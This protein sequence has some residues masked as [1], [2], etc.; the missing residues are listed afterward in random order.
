M[1]GEITI[2]PSCFPKVQYQRF[3]AVEAA[4]ARTE[5]GKQF[6]PYYCPECKAWHIKD[7]TKPKAVKG[8]QWTD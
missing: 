8:Q 3:R 5:K 2:R 7:V 1:E 4:I 6:D